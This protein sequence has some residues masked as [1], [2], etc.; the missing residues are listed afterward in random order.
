MWARGNV[1]FRPNLA[2]SISLWDMFITHRWKLGRNMLVGG[3]TVPSLLRSAARFFSLML[4]RLYSS[5]QKT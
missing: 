5:P 2:G 4:V 1:G 3:S